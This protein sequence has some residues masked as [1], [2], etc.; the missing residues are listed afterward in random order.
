[1]SERVSDVKHMHVNKIRISH[2]V[3]G[4]PIQ[5]CSILLH[6]KSPPRSPFFAPLSI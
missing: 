1:M 4:V 3:E 2:L 5:L 6:D